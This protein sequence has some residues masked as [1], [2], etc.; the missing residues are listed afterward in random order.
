MPLDALLRELQAAR[1]TLV[2]IRDLTEDLRVQ[3][4][5]AL[6]HAPGRYK[7]AGFGALTIQTRTRRQFDAGRFRAAHRDLWLRYSH[8]TPYALLKL[9]PRDGRA[10]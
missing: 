10:S 7:V 3:V 5:D 9:E 6:D 1:L 2:E 8:T 4:L